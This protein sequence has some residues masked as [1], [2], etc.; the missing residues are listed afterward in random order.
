VAARKQLQPLR[1]AGLFVAIILSSADDIG[2]NEI[3]RRRQVEDLRLAL[4]HTARAQ[5]PIAAFAGADPTPQMG[6]AHIVSDQDVGRPVDRNADRA[7]ECLPIRVDEAGE[8]YGFDHVTLTRGAAALAVATNA[9]AV[10]FSPL[11]KLLP[12]RDGRP[13]LG[14]L[15]HAKPG[16]SG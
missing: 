9:L 2:T 13:P 14:R 1:E 8:D 6:L 11:S 10:K 7:A 12:A 3:M 16:G 4:G 15:C 5:F